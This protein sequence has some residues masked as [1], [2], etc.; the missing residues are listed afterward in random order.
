M[1][2][3]PDLQ[4]RIEKIGEP[5]KEVL[6]KLA[7]DYHHEVCPNEECIVFESSPSK[8]RLHLEILLGA[9]NYLHPN[10]LENVNYNFHVGEFEGRTYTLGG[11]IAHLW[12]PQVNEKLYFRT[13]LL[14]SG[15]K[16]GRITH[17][18]MRFPI[19]AEY[20]YPKGIFR[21]KLAYGI[22]IYS[23]FFLSNGLMAGF[24]LTLNPKSSL[25]INYSLDLIPSKFP[26]F[27]SGKIF[28]QTLLAGIYFRL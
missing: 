12:L 28:S 23:P 2:D 11:L 27:P 10:D 14:F 6:I 16:E 15:Y 24:N 9:T 25:G 1:Q 20:I 18:L 21:P 22:N 7:R 19:Q 5:G 13:G 3:A 26:V 4:A 17:L 8:I